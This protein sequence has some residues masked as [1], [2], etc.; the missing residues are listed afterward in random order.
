MSIKM[1]ITKQYSGKPYIMLMNQF[2]KDLQEILGIDDNLTAKIK[3]AIN[4]AIY[5]VLEAEGEL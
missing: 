5:N 1:D 4:V 3:F 2:G